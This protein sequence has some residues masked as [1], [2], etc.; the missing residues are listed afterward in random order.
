MKT[1]MLELLAR[2]AEDWNETTA[3]LVDLA[4]GTLMRQSGVQRISFTATELRYTMERFVILRRMEITPLG[5]EWTISL[6]PREPGDEQQE[7]P[8]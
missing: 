3:A 5:P 8:L 6:Y 1:E 7:L 4:V 2:T